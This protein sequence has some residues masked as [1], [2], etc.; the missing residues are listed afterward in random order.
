MHLNTHRPAPTESPIDY[1][2]EDDPN[3]VGLPA[4]LALILIG[5]ING[6]LISIA[7]ALAIAIHLSKHG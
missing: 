4:C 7:I 5:T 2:C 1:E 3:T 6:I